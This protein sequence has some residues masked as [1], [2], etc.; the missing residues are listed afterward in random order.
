MIDPSRGVLFRDSFSYREID[1]A[2]LVSH[3][4][5]AHGGHYFV[6]L[7]EVGQ[8]TSG[9]PH[10]ADVRFQ[11]QQLLLDRVELFVS[12]IVELGGIGL[13]EAENLGCHVHGGKVVPH[14]NLAAI[15]RIPENIP[16][17]WSLWES[18]SVINQ[19]IC[20]PHERHTV[21]LSFHADQG[22]VSELRREATVAGNLGEIERQSQTSRRDRRRHV[23]RG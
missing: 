18:R 13:V 3:Q 7:K 8:L 21:H 23:A 1:L 17:V 11:F 15:L 4:R 20:S 19:R 9:G 12:E 2:K 16:S 5:P 22:K 14:G 10:L 6:I